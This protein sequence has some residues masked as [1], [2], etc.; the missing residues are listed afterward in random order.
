MQQGLLVKSWPTVLVCEAAGVVA[1]V[2]EGVSGF[3]VGDRAFG[4]TKVGSSV[5]MAFQ[6][7]VCSS[8]ALV[9]FKEI[10]Y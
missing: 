3:S 7:L 2:G 9:V 6:E 10:T 5:Y 8:M 1:E 4:V